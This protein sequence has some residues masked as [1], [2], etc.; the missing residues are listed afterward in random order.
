MN[1]PFIHCYPSKT[2]SISKCWS[3][4]RSARRLRVGKSRRIRLSGK[5]WNCTLGMWKRKSRNKSWW[6]M[7]SMWSWLHKIASKRKPTQ[8]FSNSSLEATEPYI[9]TKKQLLKWRKARKRL[10]NQSRQS[11]NGP[12]MGIW[13]KNYWPITQKTSSI[14]SRRCSTLLISSIRKQETNDFE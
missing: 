11:S 9:W 8:A 5:Y 10:S 3:W 7:R 14:T 1:P 12:I 13:S 4:S 2:R 6:R